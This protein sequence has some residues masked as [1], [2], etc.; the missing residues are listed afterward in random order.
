MTRRIL[1]PVI[2]GLLLVVGLGGCGRK[3]APLPPVVR[4]AAETRDLAVHQEG[5]DT[6]LAWS[7]PTSTSVGGPLPDLEEIEIWRITFPRNQEPSPDEQGDRTVV[8][9]LFTARGERIG[10]LDV[11]GI[12][13]A[14]RGPLLTHSDDLLSWY[15][16]HKEVGPAVLWYAVRSRCCRRRLNEYSN[17]AR[18]A[19]QSPPPP[20]TAL[21]ANA[22]PGGVELRWEAHE[23]MAVLVERA[24]EGRRWRRV[25]EQPIEGSGWTDEGATQGQVWTYRLRSV[26][27]GGDGALT[28]GQAGDSATIDYQDVYPPE[29]PLNLVC[30]PEGQRVRLRWQ[31]AGDGSEY[32]VLR[33]KDGGAWRQL[34]S[35]VTAAA[36]EDRLPPS[37]HLVY[38]V[39]AVDKAGN[40][41]ESATC[42]TVVGNTR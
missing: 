31:A 23:G 39:R 6:V 3:A 29:V 7:Y 8:A 16:E 13:A 26:A 24:Q 33:Q 28:I 18:L 25:R 30:L 21:R 40:Q 34:S 11:V 38:A 4:M 37:G 5:T 10:I 1:Q 12:D 27:T 15:E 20:P 35:R 19:P 36:F 14:T 41:S 22:S 17:L 32:L 42:S 2:A 9:Q